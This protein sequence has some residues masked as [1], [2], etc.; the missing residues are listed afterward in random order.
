M[1]ETC[2]GTTTFEGRIVRCE[3]DA[4]HR[5]DT[6]HNLSLEGDHCL[7]W[8]EPGDPLP[9]LL[10]DAEWRQYDLPDVTVTVEP[11]PV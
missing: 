4:S 11:P 9:E 5:P 3:L 7:A 8:G 2:H 1:A 6:L 10:T